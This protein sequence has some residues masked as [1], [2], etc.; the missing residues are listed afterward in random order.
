MKEKFIFSLISQLIR[1]LISLT[2]TYLFILYL[3]P[4]LLGKWALFNSI[5]NLGFMFADLGLEQIHFQYSEKENF[6]EYFGSFVV[7]KGILI[8]INIF[9]SLL[10]IS[11]FNLWE[12]I[13]IGIVLLISFTK[14]IT[15]I[16]GIFLAQ[17]K[18]K[19]KVFKAEFSILI[20]TIGQ[21][22]A[23][24]YI[25]LNM[26]YF[27]D[28]LFWLSII[29]LI[30]T[31]FYALIVFIL[32][33][34]EIEVNKWNKNYIRSY[35][36]DTK[37]LM[38]YSILFVA[39]SNIGNIILNYSFSSASL[40]YFY[41][42]NGYII[43]ILGIFSTSIITICLPLFSQY[44]ANNN[45]TEVERITY[46]IE[47]YTSVLYL[48]IILII[49]LAGDSI[50]SL[51][52]PSYLNSLPLLNILTI[53]SYL[54]AINRT[55]SLILISGKKQNLAAYISTFNL[56]LQ[57]ILFLLLIPKTIFSVPMF[58]LGAIG[59]ALSILIVNMTGLILVR[60]FVL[61]NFNIKSQI[62]IIFQILIALSTYLIIFS[63]KVLLL[64]ILIQNQKILTTIII[65]SSL[66][67]FFLQLF[68]FKILKKDD[69]KFFY[70]LL[71]V[72][73]YTQSIKKEFVN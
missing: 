60:L 22:V 21:S 29:N 68:V 6:N 61:K 51:F 41:L 15:A 3:D 34:N 16:L 4:T 11:I 20:I 46:L 42:I 36:K 39:G 45:N 67:L 53:S 48:N 27:I 71:K 35:L 69:L 32:G 56:I 9:I 23:K 8:V 5:V 47:K 14:I 18:A 17:V 25:A 31:L 24:I 13:Y 2:A 40:G 50:F 38:I 58:G 66:G 30:F 64:D 28:P 7:I 59:Y 43:P 10:L 63:F 49:Y 44:I 65:I 73:I 19:L 70:D 33:R 52:L 55:Y 37:P 62:K 26:E 12:S 72:K 1:H 57:L 54:G